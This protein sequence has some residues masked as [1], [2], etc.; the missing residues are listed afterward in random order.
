MGLSRAIESAVEHVT[1][2]NLDGFFIHLDADSLNDTIMPA[3]DYRLD[4]GFSWDEMTDLLQA[5]LSSERAVGMELT[6]YN[7][8]LDEDGTA[9]RA[10]TNVLVA[11]LGPAPA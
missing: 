4:G 11:V 6:I 3:V 7:P 1:R 10:L 5:A 9:G 2:P 8:A